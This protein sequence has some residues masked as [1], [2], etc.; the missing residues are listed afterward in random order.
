MRIFRRLIQSSPGFQTW[1]R[2]RTVRA[3]KQAPETSATIQISSPTPEPTKVGR[4]FQGASFRVTDPGVNPWA[5]LYNPPRRVM[6][7][8]PVESSQE[9]RSAESPGNEI[10]AERHESRHQRALCR[11]ERA[12]C[13]LRESEKIEAGAGSRDCW[14][15]PCPDLR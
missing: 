2:C 10:R 5:V 4:H 14:I 1:V 15:R 8:T 13:V 3:L 12:C 7:A 9:H 11:D 6:T